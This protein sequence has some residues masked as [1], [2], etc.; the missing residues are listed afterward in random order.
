MIVVPETVGWLGIAAVESTEREMVGLGRGRRRRGCVPW[1]ARQQQSGIDR[2]CAVRGLQ[3]ELLLVELLLLFLM[4]LLLLL[5]LQ[6]QLELLL[7]M[8]LMLLL[9]VQMLL[10]VLDVTVMVKLSGR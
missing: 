7:Q 10:L 1:A 6:L 2:Q 4:V 9:D 5:H 3:L 8:E